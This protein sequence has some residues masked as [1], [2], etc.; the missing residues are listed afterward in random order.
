[1]TP[2]AS[3]EPISVCQDSE[4]F[5]QTDLLAIMAQSRECDRREGI[6]LRQGKGHFQMPAAG[7]EAVAVIA[8]H[9]LPGDYIY[10]YYRDRAL[11][12]A[13]GVPLSEF[14]HSYFAKADSSSQGRQMPNH[15]SDRAR[16]VVSAASPTGLQ[17]LPAAGTAWAC[18][19][20]GK[21]AVSV[22][23]IGDSAIRQGEVYESWCF[24]VQENLPFV[25]VV[26]DNGYGI[27]TPT[28]NLNPLRLGTLAGRI[29][30]VDGR[31]VDEVDRTAAALIRDARAGGGPAILWVE[32]DRLSSH[33]SS[34]D[35]RLYRAETDL[36]AMAERDPIQ[37]LERELLSGG[38]F[39]AADLADMRSRISRE[40][41]RE[42]RIA[43]T[44]AEPD[45]RFPTDQIFSG[46]RLASA[47]AL[48]PDNRPWT[49]LAA[50]QHTLRSLLESDERVLLFGQD[51]EDPKGGVFGLTKGLST[52]FLAGFA[53]RRSRKRRLQE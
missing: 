16:N 27:S 11:L 15:F 32:L 28:E 17:C 38:S 22:C 18:K 50:F 48:L 45:A 43:E 52:D 29:V 1:M 23:L 10:P 14:A 51:I 47:R 49:L 24:A 53:M 46:N 12:L 35:Q 36:A 4:S 9:L 39:T 3:I 21:G 8:R 34:D 44:A 31:D 42:Y 20:S 25:L 33:T 7:H 26:E 30:K 37:L 41:E 5:S 19:I 13:L 6:L 40:V 2:D